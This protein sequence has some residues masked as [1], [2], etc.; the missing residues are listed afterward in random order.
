MIKKLY[1]NRVQ[2]QNPKS[3]QWIKI[4]TSIGIILGRKKTPYKNVRKVK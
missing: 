3:K 4:N 2:L 1:K